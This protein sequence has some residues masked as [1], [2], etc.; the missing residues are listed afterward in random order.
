MSTTASP[1]ILV[2]GATGNIV[3]EL[4]KQLVDRNVLF[5]ALIRSAKDRDKLV[6]LPGVDLV[7]GDFNDSA[8]L[9]RVLAGVEKAF[10]LTNSSEQAESQQL[11]FVAEAKRAGLNHV[12]KLSQLGAG[13]A[14]PVRFLRYHA[15]VKAA[16]RESG[17]AYTFLRPNLFMQGLL[18]FRDSIVGQ[19]QFVAAIGDAKVSLVDGRDIAA[20]GAAALTEPDHVNQIYTLTEPQALTHAELAS[21]LTKALGRPITFINVTPEAMRGALEQ[22]NFPAWQADGLIEDYAHYGRHE[23][24][25]VTADVETATE[26]QPYSFAEFAHEYAGAFS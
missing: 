18:G 2:T 7:E 16:I 23:A 9:S 24:A 6:H 13:P 22:A 21:E 20:V 3:T 11:R 12:I 25:V 10:L 5:Q 8:S 14:S 17:M 26:R 4:V 19:K 15:V 1:K